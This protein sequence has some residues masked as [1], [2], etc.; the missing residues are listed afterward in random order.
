MA[1]VF[2]L[3]FAQ[4]VPISFVSNTLPI[5]YRSHGLE[6]SNFWVFSLPLV[7]RWL[8][9][10]IAPAI[11][12]YMPLPIGRRRSWILLG[13]LVGACGYGSLT[14]WQPTQASLYMIVA[15]LTVTAVAM[16]LQDIA[17]DGYTVES[18]SPHEAKF[19]GPLLSGVAFASLI[20]ASAVVGVVYD[21]FGWSS[22]VAC[23]IAALILGTLPAILRAEP[24]AESLRQHAEQRN[25][26]PSLMKVFTRSNALRFIAVFALEAFYGSFTYGL[27][28]VMLVDKGLS[29]GQIGIA[30]G[31]GVGLGLLLGTIGTTLLFLRFSTKQLCLIALIGVAGAHGIEVYVT[32]LDAVSMTT[33]IVT[34]F[35]ADLLV[36]PLFALSTS[37]RIRWT[38]RRQAGT[39]FATLSSVRAMGDSLAGVTSGFAAQWLGWTAF[40]GVGMVF[41]VLVCIALFLLH[42]RMEATLRAEEEADR[43]LAAE[44]DTD[45]TALAAP[46]SGPAATA[47]LPPSS[48]SSAAPMAP[49]P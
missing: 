11:D 20:F 12:R 5:I 29:V 30:T 36:A 10:L 26:K 23:V 32:T 15:V 46:L 33:A 42:D 7:P 40:F 44:A 19:S 3:L 37:L 49:K 31:S 43:G 27:Y 2:A 24:I 48:C 39:D 14:L 6:L 18:F 41:G 8:K 17:V 9:W 4:A 35:V 1:T 47:T 38:S 34:F 25:G 13:T 21:S 28:S 45:Q 16:T 22:A